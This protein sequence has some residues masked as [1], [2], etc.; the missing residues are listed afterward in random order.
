LARIDINRDLY[1]EE[2][3]EQFENRP[4]RLDACIKSMSRTNLILI[5][6]IF[7]LKQTWYL[8]IFSELYTFIRKYPEF[9]PNEIEVIYEKM[10]NTLVQTQE[11]REEI[12]FI[13][14]LPEFSGQR[15]SIYQIK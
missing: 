3:I 12:L 5:L 11:F 4:A 1:W 9:P 15:P 14:L 8:N 7:K 13:N 6:D 10:K 2:L